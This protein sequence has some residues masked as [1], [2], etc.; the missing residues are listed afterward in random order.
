[1]SQSPKPKPE[2]LPHTEASLLDL[3]IAM[4]GS[5]S[6]QLATKGYTERA[7][8]EASLT[9]LVERLSALSGWHI[10][11]VPEPWFGRAVG[12]SAWANTNTYGTLY[13]TP[14]FLDPANTDERRALAASLLGNLALPPLSGLRC[15]PLADWVAKLVIAAEA[16]E[17]RR[18]EEERVTPTFAR[19]AQSFEAIRIARRETLGI[20]L[21]G[22]FATE[23][24][25]ETFRLIHDVEPPERAY[26]LAL[27]AAGNHLN[28]DPTG[29][30]RLTALFDDLVAER[31]ADLHQYNYGAKQKYVRRGIRLARRMSPADV[32]T[33]PRS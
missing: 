11:F 12:R 22:A 31:K 6:I 1:M 24:E 21:A 13:A 17:L 25:L 9:A 7:Y 20:W 33:L 3:P 2:I 10:E 5:L 30:P 15:L 29:D 32:L 16:H 19:K 4:A 26:A 18:L 27:L 14:R 8:A 23:S 28:Y